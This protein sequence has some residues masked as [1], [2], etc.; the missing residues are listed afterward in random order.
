MGDISFST[1]SANGLIALSGCRSGTLLSGEIKVSIVACFVSDP[2][3][4]SGDHI[5]DL[6]SIPAGPFF[7][8]LLEARDRPKGLGKLAESGDYVNCGGLPPAPGSPA[9]GGGGLPPAPG[10][11]ASGGGPRL[12]S[13][14]KNVP[15]P[16]AGSLF[17]LRTPAERGRSC[18][19]APRRTSSSTT[20]RFSLT[21]PSSA[22]AASRASSCELAV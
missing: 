6:L 2:R 16:S 20:K 7:N 3:M 4:P 8:T 17:H 9:S 5:R 14:A 21:I 19:R 1:V 12:P 15:I 11:P 18:T 22:S 13:N 10:S